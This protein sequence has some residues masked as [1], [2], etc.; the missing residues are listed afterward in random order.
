MYSEPYLQVRSNSLYQYNLVPRLPVGS[1]A[2]QEKRQQQLLSVQHLQEH[3]TYTGVLTDGAKKR[4]TK[5]VENLIMASKLR[6][7]H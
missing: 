1:L 4:L 2:W 7:S 6:S 3:A 5:S